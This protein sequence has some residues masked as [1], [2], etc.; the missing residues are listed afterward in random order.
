MYAPVVQS[1]GGMHKYL[2]VVHEGAVSFLRIHTAGMAEKASANA[3]PY[4][5]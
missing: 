5:R 4:A 2:L 3:S 1:T